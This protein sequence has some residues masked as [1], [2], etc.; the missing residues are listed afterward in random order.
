MEIK[1]SLSSPS[2]INLSGPPEIKE[3]Q[4]VHKILISDKFCHTP[5]ELLFL[6]Q[7]FGTCLFLCAIY[8]H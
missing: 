4:A 7:L 2:I 8:G 1:L 5:S 3:N 6:K